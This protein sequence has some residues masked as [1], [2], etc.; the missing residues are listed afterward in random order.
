MW[1]GIIRR[2]WPVLAWW[3]LIWLV[4]AC[5]VGKELAFSR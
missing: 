5:G 1:L 3:S 4:A 2:W